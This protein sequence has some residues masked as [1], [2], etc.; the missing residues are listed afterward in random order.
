VWT[1]RADSDYLSPDVC[2]WTDDDGSEC[3]F[4]RCVLEIPIRGHSEPFTWGVWGSLSEANFQRAL[5]LWDDAARLA[6]PP[7]FSWLSNEIPGYPGSEGLPCA[8]TV[9]A[10]DDRPVLAVRDDA[11]H[12]L[13][14]DQRA[15]V[16]FDRALALASAAMHSNDS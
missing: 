12:A 11:D 10:V 9:T 8:M 16:D 4:L 3:Y 7:Y 5:S 13:V 2:V 15:G 6:E 1:P 14:V